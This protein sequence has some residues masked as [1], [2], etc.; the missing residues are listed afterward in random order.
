[1]EKRGVTLI[2]LIVVM[3]IIA[4]MGLF[5]APSIGQWLDNFH[6]RQAA[7]D[8]VSTLQ[9]AK[10]QAIS[11]R[12]VN[13][14]VTVNFT[15]TTYQITPGGGNSQVPTGVT[16]NTLSI[17]FNPDGTSTGGIITINSTKNTQQYQVSV[18]PTGSIQM[19]QIQ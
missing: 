19:Q 4:I 6:I 14:P 12:Q 18:L 15:P 1:M 13:P 8:I 16:I 3:A 9:L 11:T 17:S 2:E 7:R 10:M 5:I